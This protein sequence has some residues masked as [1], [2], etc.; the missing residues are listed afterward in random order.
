MKKQLLQN[1]KFI[2]IGMALVAG[3]GFAYADGWTTPT[4]GAPA[5]NIDVPLHTGPTQ[6]KNGG[7]GV[8]T[9]AVAQNAAFLQ[10]TYLNGAIEGGIPGGL[11]QVSIGGTDGKGTH[12]IPVTV[13]GDVTSTGIISNDPV[14]TSSTDNNLCATA[15]GTIQLCTT[16]TPGPGGASELSVN[17][18]DATLNA[19]STDPTVINEIEA[20]ITPIVSVPVTVTVNAYDPE[21]LADRTDG[22]TLPTT[23]TTIGTLIILAEKSSSS[24]MEYP[25]N[26]ESD[27]D[28]IRLSIQGYTPTVDSGT[29]YPIND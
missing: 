14:A 8:G 9:F 7:L 3:F 25:T 1:F 27:A 6:V 21:P 15:N 20:E 26:C 24:D 28:F 5:G 22:C 11:A 13:A 19:G 2:L 23:P 10:Q 12:T 4:S 18:V 16:S 29:G 17:D